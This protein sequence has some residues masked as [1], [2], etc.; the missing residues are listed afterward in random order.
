MAAVSFSI[1]EI[2]V[3]KSG[4]PVRRPASYGAMPCFYTSGVEDIPQAIP[5]STFSRIDGRDKKS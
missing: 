4:N 3:Q 1:A 2:T 5:R